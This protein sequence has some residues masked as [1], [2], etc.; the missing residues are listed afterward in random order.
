VSAPVD[1]VAF[2]LGAAVS[3]GASWLLVSRIERM[4]N[5]LAVTEAMLGLIAALAA[6]TPEITSAISALASHQHEIGSSVVVGSNVFNLAALLGL[7]AVVAGW[8]ALHRRVVLL[9][10]GISLWIAAACV[11]VVFGDLPPFVG[12]LLVAAVLGPYAFL[13]GS[14]RVRQGRSRAG[15]WL[16]T[17]IREEDL[18]LHPALIPGSK[19]LDLAVTAGALVVVVGA[20]VVMERSA[21]S[22]GTRFAVPDVVVGGLVL[23]AVTS[24]P[25][26]VAAVYLARRGRG[27]AMLSTALNSNALNIAFGLLL[28]AAVVGLGATT[29][30]EVLVALWYAGLTVVVLLFAYRDRGLR[31]HTGMVV[32]VAYALFAVVLVVTGLGHG[33]R[34]WYLGPPALIGV[35]TLVLLLTPAHHPPADEPPPLPDDVGAAAS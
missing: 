27:T 24:L 22:L 15:R 34:L 3:L 16:T 17:A 14:R 9:T 2:V 26:A 10:G 13:A 1:A 32:L 30:R 7:G 5:R 33:N 4:G 20:S 31:R 8:V 28:P 12:L 23:A 11:L 35:W 18:E 21:Q 6:D 25:N 19:R 29:S